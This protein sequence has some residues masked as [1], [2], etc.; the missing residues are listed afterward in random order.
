[1]IEDVAI[2]AAVIPWAEANGLDASAFSGFHQYVLTN[3]GQDMT[4]TTAG[5]LDMDGNNADQT[6]T[7]T[8]EEL[9]Y[10]KGVR[11]YNA[12]D[13]TFEREWDG[14][15]SLQGSYTWSQSKGNT[16]GTV[17]SDNGQDDAGLTQDF[18]QPGLTDGAYGFLPNHRT[19]RF[20]VW[21]S[22]Q[23]TDWM[24]VGALL[25][26]ESPRKQG[27]IGEHYTDYF[28][29]GYGAASWYCN[30]LP[31]PRGQSMQTDWTKNLDLSFN[32]TPAISAK[33]PGEL[34]FRV[35][36]FNVFNSAA[37]AD[38]WEYGDQGFSGYNAYGLYTNQPQYVGPGQTTPDP[39]YGK[40][41]RFQ[42]PR[43]VRFSASYRF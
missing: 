17:K 18:D 24:N 1:M 20:K 38:R 21:G 30:D 40:P 36:V 25:N 32:I 3:P 28:A 23:V 5:V 8:A 27:C 11:T 29:W 2:D 41:T 33:M 4:I 31:T 12:V 39:D 13:F 37:V 16:E 6:V 26:V 42:A 10:P 35:D 22:Y 15:W 19:H 9:G 7:F 14:V 43:R 34:S